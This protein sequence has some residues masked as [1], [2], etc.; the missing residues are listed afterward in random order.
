MHFS[1]VKFYFLLV[2]HYAAMKY[3]NATESDTVEYDTMEYDTM[4]F[5]TKDST[6]IK[7]VGKRVE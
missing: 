1:I 5:D 3:A 6:K 2:L 4:E 7:S